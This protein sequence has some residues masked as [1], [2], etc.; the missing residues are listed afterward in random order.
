MWEFSLCFFAPYKVNIPVYAGEFFLCYFSVLFKVNI[1]MYAGRFKQVPYKEY[2]CWIQV[3]I[4]I[5]DQ[6][7]MRICNSVGLTVDSGIGLPNAHGK[8]VGIDSGVD[9]RRGYSQLRHKVPF[10]MFSMDSA[11]TLSPQSPSQQTRPQQRLYL[12]YL[13]HSLS[14][15]FVAIFMQRRIM[16]YNILL[17]RL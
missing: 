14:S 12:P 5:S 4:H 1:P 7:S 8:C 13:T 10:I 2:I 9:I 6:T 11:W 3:K 16:F 15:H 17:V